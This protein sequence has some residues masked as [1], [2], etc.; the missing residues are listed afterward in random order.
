MKK[1]M[2]K[3]RLRWYPITVHTAGHRMCL[4]LYRRS[5]RSILMSSK[6][7]RNVLELP[8]VLLQLSL[9]ALSKAM[10]RCLQRGRNLNHMR[11]LQQLTRPFPERARPLKTGLRWLKMSFR[12]SVEKRRRVKKNL[13]EYGVRLRTEKLFL[14]PAL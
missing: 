7:R 13:S 10:H 4:W 3:Q 9:T 8:E 6:H 1:N 12:I 5:I 14:L 11:L 2:P